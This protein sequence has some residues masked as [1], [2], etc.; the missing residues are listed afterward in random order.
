MLLC[1][2]QGL[3]KLLLHVFTV[4]QTE[5]K[6]KCFSG[7]VLSRGDSVW[8]TSSSKL[9]RGTL[10]ITVVNYCR[11]E[12]CFQTLRSLGCM[13]FKNWWKCVHLSIRLRRPLSLPHP[14][15]IPPLTALWRS[16]ALN[17]SPMVLSWM[18]TLLTLSCTVLSLG[19][20]WC[21]ES[22]DRCSVGGSRSGRGP[23]LW[24]GSCCGPWPKPATERHQTKSGC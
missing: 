20:L 7:A 10:M 1:W 19:P 18:A 24:Q 17:S 12:I 8:V 16:V 21:D 2:P 15:L 23:S 6:E 11:G 22:L 5:T 14:L 9:L 13:P 4:A 3:W